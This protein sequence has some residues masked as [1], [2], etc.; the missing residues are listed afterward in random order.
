MYVCVCVCVYVCVCVFVLCVLDLE[1]TKH[2]ICKGK[3]VVWYSK[4]GKHDENQK[5]Y[6]KRQKKYNRWNG[7]KIMQHDYAFE[8]SKW[9][10]T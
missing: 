2:H 5:R 4:H 3:L 1:D 7:Q 8:S 9:S 6:D 10:R